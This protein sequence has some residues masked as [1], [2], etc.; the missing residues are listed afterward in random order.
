MF[1]YGHRF[2]KTFIGQFKVHGIILRTFYCIK[3]QCI[4]EVYGANLTIHHSE[5]EVQGINV[6]KDSCNMKV[7]FAEVRNGI[8]QVCAQC[9]SA[10][11]EKCVSHIHIRFLPPHITKKTPKHQLTIF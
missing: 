6:A 9:I 7:S 4:L 8:T 1:L 11:I 5:T 2:S 10:Y 3:P